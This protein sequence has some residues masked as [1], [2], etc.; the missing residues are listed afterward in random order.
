MKSEF[1]LTHRVDLKFP[2]SEKKGEYLWYEV[3]TV[4]ND[5]F[6]IGTI[7]RHPEGNVKHFT[8]KVERNIE[9]IIKS[10]GRFP[11]FTETTHSELASA[12]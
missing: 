4:N 6:L 9:T 8:D 12:R 7:Y 10:K 5:T 1:K 2:N 3:T 11:L